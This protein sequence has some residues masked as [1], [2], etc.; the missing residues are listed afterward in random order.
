MKSRGRF[1][2]H[3]ARLVHGWKEKEK[4]EIIKGFKFN[5]FSILLIEGGKKFYRI[6]RDRTFSLISIELDCLVH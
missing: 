6:S 2:A 5:F 3:F 1:S 4:K